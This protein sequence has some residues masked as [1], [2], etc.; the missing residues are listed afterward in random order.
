MYHPLSSLLI[1]PFSSLVCLFPFF[2]IWISLHLSLH[3]ILD[4]ILSLSFLISFLPI[5][6]H[7]LLPPSFCLYPLSFFFRPRSVVRWRL[8][9]CW[10]RGNLSCD[11]VHRSVI[12]FFHP[13]LWVWSHHGT[14]MV[15][16][17]LSIWKQSNFFHYLTEMRENWPCWQP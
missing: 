8:S 10:W 17:I 4:C 1:L 2:L 11:F 14:L 16:T 6:Q 9:S 15:I 5:S 12:S 7:S 3:S 13:L